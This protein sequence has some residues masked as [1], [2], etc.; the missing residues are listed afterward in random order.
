MK[1]ADSASS[2]H[3]SVLGR[4][5]GQKIVAAVRRGMSK[6]QAARTSGVGA[7]SL[8][9]HVK[10]VEQGKPLSSGKAP[11]QKVKLDGSGT[12]RLEQDLL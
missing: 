11:G 12:K 2:E 8:K 7:T 10:L 5:Q 3:E 4:P 6:A 9:R 1:L